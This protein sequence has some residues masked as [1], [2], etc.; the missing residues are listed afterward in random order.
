[1]SVP[2]WMSVDV[3]EKMKAGNLQIID[4]REPQEFED[5][6]IPGAKLIP[7]GQLDS[8]YQEINPDQQAVIVCRSGGRSSVA[9]DFLSRVGYQNIHNLMG[10]MNAWN[11]EVAY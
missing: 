11:G 2:Q 9:C 3:I 5:G 10:G 1:M 4:V 6:H 7:L 8:R